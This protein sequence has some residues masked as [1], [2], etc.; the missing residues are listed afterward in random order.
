VDSVGVPRDPTYSGTFR[1]VMLLSRT[2]LSPPMAC[3]SSTVLLADHFVTPMWKALQPR[4]GKP[5]RFGLFPFRS[6]LLG[7]SIFLSFP[8]VTE[9]FQF[10]AFAPLGL[11]I[12]PAVI[13]LAADRVSPFGDPRIKAR[14]TAPLGI[15]QPTTSFIASSRLDIHRAPLVA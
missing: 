12:Q 5:P 1:E 10:A 6:P 13:R 15:S 14:L 7:K 9:M 4:R 2:G 11:Y 8:A 3:L